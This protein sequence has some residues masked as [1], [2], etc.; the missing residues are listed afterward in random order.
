MFPLDKKRKGQKYKN[1]SDASLC[2]FSDPNKR[3][4]NREF[5]K[6]WIDT[7]SSEGVKPEFIDRQTKVNF[8]IYVPKKAVSN[9]ALYNYVLISLIIPINCNT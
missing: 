2:E 3:L 8:L 1:D 9:Y 7:V 4:E 6:E 5:N